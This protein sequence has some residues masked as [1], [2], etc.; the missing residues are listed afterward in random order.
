MKSFINLSVLT[1]LLFFVF[2]CG[3]AP[4]GEEAKTG[5]AAPVQSEASAA[6]ATE[7]A[8]PMTIDLDSSKFS[9]KA[10][11]LMGG[12]HNGTFTLSAGN[13]FVKD[14]Q[15]V[16][17]KFT[18]DMNSLANLDIEDSGKKGK[19][20][21]HLKSDEFFNT[22]AHPTATFVITEAIPSTETD[23]KRQK[24]T[25][26]LTMKDITKSITL[27]VKVNPSENGLSASTG[28]FVIDR[29]EWDVKYGSGLIGTA[30]DQII[31]DKV[32]IDIYLVAAKSEG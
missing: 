8:T 1:A 32:Q 10:T 5:E 27:F 30:K 19:L 17:G 6:I 12:G 26:N 14:N 16:A 3:D 29:T 2:S 20:E 28:S 24:I 7:G 18:I 13:L 11:K 23:N 25:G 31:N 4:K 9:W 15:I 21:G 22:G